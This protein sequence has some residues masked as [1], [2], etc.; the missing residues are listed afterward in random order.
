MPQ[1]TAFLYKDHKPESFRTTCLIFNGAF[2]LLSLSYILCKS[3]VLKETVE[4]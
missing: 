3:L 1:G 2:H 4:E